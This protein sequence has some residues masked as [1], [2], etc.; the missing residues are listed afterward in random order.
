ML[1]YVKLLWCSGVAYIYSQLEE[2]MG[3]IC[4]GYMYILLYIKSMWCNGFPDIYPRLEEGGGVNLPRVYV[5][6]AIYETYVV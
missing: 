4:H 5:L 3:P 2:G 1:I 6:S